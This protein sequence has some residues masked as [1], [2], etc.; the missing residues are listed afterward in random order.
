MKED[1]I[2]YSICTEEIL[3]ESQKSF[4]QKNILLIILIIISL[5]IFVLLSILLIRSYRNSKNSKKDNLDHDIYVAPVLIKRES[6]VTVGDIN[7]NNN[8]DNNNINN[9]NAGRRISQMSSLGLSPNENLNLYIPSTTE[10]NQRLSIS[11]F[12]SNSSS[13]SP[14]NTINKRNTTPLHSTISSFPTHSLSSPTESIPITQN[15]KRQSIDNKHSIYPIP[16]VSGNHIPEQSLSETNRRSYILARPS[17]AYYY[18]RSEIQSPTSPNE[19]YLP[20]T[21]KK[22]EALGSVNEEMEFDENDKSLTL[23][24]YS[25]PVGDPTI[26]YQIDSLQNTTTTNNN[27]KN[28]NNNNYN[29]NYNNSDNENSNTNNN[30]NNNNNNGS[31]GSGRSDNNNHNNTGNEMDTNNENNNNENTNT[32]TNNYDRSHNNNNDNNNNNDFNNQNSNDLSN[33]INHN[34]S[35]YYNTNTNEIIGNGLSNTIVQQISL[36]NNNNNNNTNNNIDL[37]SY[38]E[39]EIEPLDENNLNY[40]TSSSKKYHKKNESRIH[41]LDNTSDI[42]S[43]NEHIGSDNP[44]MDGSSNKNEIIHKKESFNKNDEKNKNDNISK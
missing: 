1:E 36:N 3:K 40:N 39:L 24:P 26:I 31:S 38:S 21:L 23:P 17:T 5:L 22:M 4:F 9:N 15:I 19:I 35:L 42:S 41:L 18:N 34:V 37:P 29:N 20:S 16:R 44:S 7:D 8:I 11:S 25:E 30:N 43:L 13:I 32:N 10:V 28:N 12:N 2:P 6:I 27:N 14:M 33:I